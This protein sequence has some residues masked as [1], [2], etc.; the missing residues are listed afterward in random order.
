M[1]KDSLR[2]FELIVIGGSAGSL[3]VIMQVLPVLPPD[4]HAS[5]ILV[6]H[7]K[8]G[9]SLLTKLLTGKTKLPVMEAE[10]KE[11][12]RHGT[13]YIAPPD[14]HLLIEKDRTISL[15]YSE[16]INYSRPSID[17]TFETAAEVF[18]SQ[19]AA[20]L[21][22]GA[23][24]DGAEGMQLVKKMGGFTVAQKPSDSSVDV[25][26]LAAINRAAV[27]K[28]MTIEEMKQWFASLSS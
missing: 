14:Y 28:I 20:V 15:D 27:S 4:L 6:V 22:S 1:E 8:T 2:K 7:R 10:D 25:M 18:H 5:I 19:M 11:T 21:L 13:I 12:L 3:E 9:D 24:A 17:V 23:N 16:K 26:P